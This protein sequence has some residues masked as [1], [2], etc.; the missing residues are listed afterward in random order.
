MPGPASFELSEEIQALAQPHLY[1]I[2]N[3]VDPSEGDPGSLLEGILTFYPK[4]GLS[5]TIVL[6]AAVEAV[7]DNSGNIT[8]PEVF[9]VYRSL[10]K[11]ASSVP[12][13]IMSK[14]LDSISSGLQA[15]LDATVRDIESGDR[16]SYMEHKTP[17]EMYAFLLNWFVRAAANVKVGG[18]DVASAPTGRK[19]RGGKSG[20]GRGGGRGAA[21]KKGSLHNENWTWADQ[22]PGTLA[23]ISK[24]LF[25]IQTQRLWTTTPEREAFVQQVL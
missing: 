20:A 7:A 13:L 1:S 11:H 10:L 6:T 5:D 2:P 9:D 17:L 21:A 12:G 4:Q 24:V 16:D 14:L 3:E 8:D 22:I 15:E 19:G 25:R 18:D 23:L